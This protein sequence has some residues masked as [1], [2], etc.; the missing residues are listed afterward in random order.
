[1]TNHIQY[2]SQVYFATKCINMQWGSH[3]QTTAAVNKNTSCW[4]MFNDC[5]SA[6]KSN[7]QLPKALSLALPHSSQTGRRPRTLFN[8]PAASFQDLQLNWIKLLLLDLNRIFRTI[9]S[10]LGAAPACQLP[11]D[12][13][14]KLIPF[15]RIW[16]YLPHKVLVT[17]DSPIGHDYYQCYQWP[18]RTPSH[19]AAAVATA[20]QSPLMTPIPTFADSKLKDPPLRHH[21]N[22]QNFLDC[23]TV[24][25]ER[26]LA[27][28]PRE[29]L[30]TNWW[31]QSIILPIHNNLSYLITVG[32][33]GGPTPPPVT[34]SIN[35]LTF[36]QNWTGILSDF[37]LSTFVEFQLQI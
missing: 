20:C 37:D 13:H 29:E 10:N 16:N 18:H 7:P 22:D 33:R 27:R 35:P 1:M 30:V 28:L 5:Q 34:R 12:M 32:G 25:D 3:Y 23:N 14:N 17:I 19:V 26:P 24:A 2:I 11:H 9:S 31:C 36:E 8:P 21:T 4:Q 6:N 15:I